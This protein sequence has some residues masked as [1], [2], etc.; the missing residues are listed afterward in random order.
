MRYLILHHLLFT[1]AHAY[2]SWKLTI[3]ITLHAICAVVNKVLHTTQ[4]T[5]K[6]FLE[7]VQVQEQ[8]KGL[9]ENKSKPS[10]EKRLLEMTKL[11]CYIILTAIAKS[12]AIS[13]RSSY[14]SIETESKFQLTKKLFKSWSKAEIH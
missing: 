9:K 4:K 11:L 1:A 8:E 14:Y 6:F 5:Y 12:I 7:A 10:N 13:Y 3:L 2:I